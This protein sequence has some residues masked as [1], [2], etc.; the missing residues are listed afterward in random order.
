MTD[1]Q[2]TSS[3]ELPSKSL[4]E[5]QYIIAVA[6]EQLQ[7]LQKSKQ[8]SVIAQINELASSIGITIEIHDIIGDDSKKKRVEKVKR[9]PLHKYRNPNDHSQAWTG[10]GIKPK[11]VQ[12]FMN[13]GRNMEE[14]L[15]ES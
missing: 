13:E 15:I 5:L 11:W 2:S 7:V 10:R 6:Q 4:E 3:D 8:K 12:A 9:I 1:L 14:L